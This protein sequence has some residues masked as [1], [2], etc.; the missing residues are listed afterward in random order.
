MNMQSFHIFKR[1]RFIVIIFL[2]IGYNAR[3]QAPGG[4]SSGLRTWYKADAFAIGTAGGSDQ[5]VW[6][7]Q[8]TGDGIAQDAK[9][10]GEFIYPTLFPYGFTN[11]IPQYRQATPAYNYHPYIDFTKRYAS[12]LAYQARSASGNFTLN[13]SSGGG[14]LFVAGT[15]NS[16]ADFQTLAGLGYHYNTGTSVRDYGNT[17][18]YMYTYFNSLYAFT[19]PLQYDLTKWAVVPKIPY[20]NSETWSNYGTTSNAIESRQDGDVAAVNGTFASDYS[21]TGS[22]LTIGN[23][24]QWL[25][26][27]RWW[28]GGIPEVILY[29]RKLTATEYD[30]VE[31]YL[32]TKY[33]T[34]LSHNYINSAGS[35]VYNTGCDLYKNEIA[36]ISRDDNSVLNQKQAHSAYKSPVVSLSVGNIA[37]YDNANNS[38]V[39]A[40]DQTSIYWGSNMIGAAT[41]RDTKPVPAGY[42]GTTCITAINAVWTLKKWRVQEQPGKD[43]GSVKIYVE[44]K[45]V[46]ALDANCVDWYIVVGSDANFTT[47]QYYPLADAGA[48]AGSAT[49]LVA[50]INF[51]N[52]SPIATSACGGLTTQYFAIVGKE[53]TCSPGGVTGFTAWVRAEPGNVFNDTGAAFTAAY[54][55]YAM[56]MKNFSGLGDAVALWYDGATNFAVTTPATYTATFGAPTAASNFN[57][58][59]DFTQATYSGFEFHQVLTQN[60]NSPASGAFVNY[61]RTH[62]PTTA[63]ASTSHPAAPST[64]PSQVWG[65]GY[66]ASN[67]GFGVYGTAAGANTAIFHYGG[68]GTIT[69]T[70]T[71]VGNRNYQSSWYSESLGG[72]A[73]AYNTTNYS[74]GSYE[75]PFMIEK[76]GINGSLGSAKDINTSANYEYLGVNYG[77]TV[78]PT[79]IRDKNLMLRNSYRA[80]PAVES[81]LEYPA[82]HLFN[83]GYYLHDAIYF[84]KALTSAEQDR[85][86][87]YLGIRNGETILNAQ[88]LATD[89]S[90]IWDSTT[91]TDAVPDTTG[92][93][94]YNTSITGIGRDDAEC[95]EQKVSRNTVD[96]LITLA[97]NQIPADNDNTSNTGEFLKD[98]EYIIWGSNG[99]DPSRNITTDLNTGFCLTN[100]CA[101]EYRVQISGPA[102]TT[103]GSNETQIRWQNP[104]AFYDGVTAISKV[105]LLIDDDGDGDFSNAT[106]AVEATSYSNKTFIF[107]KVKL[108]PEGN[109][110]ACYTLAWSVGSPLKAVLFNGTIA[111][112]GNCTSCTGNNVLTL[113]CTDGTGWTYYKN[114]YTGASSTENIVVAINWNPSNQAVNPNAV[115]KANA[116]VRLDVHNAAAARQKTNL[117]VTIGTSI[118]DSASVIGVR[119]LNVSNTGAL[120]SPVNVKMYYDKQE[121]TNDSTWVNTPT[122]AGS[123][124]NESN[125][126]YNPGVQWFKFEGDIPATLAANTASGLPAGTPGLSGTA[127]TLTPSVDGVESGIR[128]VQF[129]DIT[130]FSTIGF[131]QSIIRTNVIQVVPVTLVDFSAALRGNT[132]NLNWITTDEQ[133]LSRFEAERSADGI[134]FKKL[135]FVN[136][137]NTPG[138]NYYTLPDDVSGLSGNIFYRLKIIDRDGKYGYSA[139]RRVSLYNMFKGIQIT[140]NPF[141]DKFQVQLTAAFNEKI[142]IN[143][144]DAKG[145]V[146]FKSTRNV[147]KG[148]NSFE[149]RLPQLAAG[150]YICEFVHEDGLYERVKL[151][152]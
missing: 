46:K 15:N 44:K 123:N 7:D 82:S 19:Y 76:T 2:L 141:V 48:T 86:E 129:N 75:Y 32:A 89:G 57:P 115:Q 17:Y 151:T 122:V 149:V 152:R 93:T 16:T 61:R 29:N 142:I 30:K 85:V 64:T 145:A 35:V 78:D 109:G 90:V 114:N 58:I 104:D 68:S 96:T 88:Y 69:G 119:L 3:T 131:Q 12:Y 55:D 135:D 33:G 70:Q 67:P 100:R 94:R 25:N 139:I 34:T 120:T 59:I 5:A 140:P 148:Q 91:Y 56:R 116:I 150:V 18:P 40:T 38:S 60:F 21:P 74:G 11:R 39:I 79:I 108:D 13:Y 49:D 112:G 127:I 77:P 37:E 126:I 147:L 71:L 54:G 87:T 23:D 102:G 97:L 124:A 138:V 117:N 31:T 73:P 128:Y 28:N 36:G 66:Y 146:I 8:Y 14:S 136:A 111:G 95:M 110:K 101:R 143:L 130:E 92:Y 105:Y 47:V 41:R 6:P 63:F 22:S 84:E 27:G 10:Y 1:K 26:G 62:G 144:Y 103:I 125:I 50:D 43:I 133:N 51:C 132:V 99:A 9:Q 107:D 65:A 24:N 113:I 53:A 42:S 134:T 45:E 80:V 20:I 137:R 4:I 118:Y 81:H 121:Q 98:R 106:R 83:T 72:S 52:G